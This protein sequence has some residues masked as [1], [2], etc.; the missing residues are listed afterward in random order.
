MRSS[1]G[2]M[3]QLSGASLERGA[4][5]TTDGHMGVNQASE[6]LD[7]QCEKMKVRMLACPHYARGSLLHEQVTITF[8]LLN[9]VSTS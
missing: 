6:K 3:Q 4:L 5:D 9:P 1:G 8:L 2:Q 7:Q